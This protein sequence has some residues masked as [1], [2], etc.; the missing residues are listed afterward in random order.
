[1]PPR[2]ISI[3]LSVVFTPP[4]SLPVVPPPSSTGTAIGSGTQSLNGIDDS[5]FFRSEVHDFRAKSGH[6]LL[7]AI[8]PATAP[9]ILNK[10]LL[11]LPVAGQG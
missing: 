5:A 2:S 8:R 4:V 7:G 11:V 6:T 3:N 10:G 9:V 1:M